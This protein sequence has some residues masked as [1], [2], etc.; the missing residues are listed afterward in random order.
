MRLIRRTGLAVVLGIYACAL[1]AGAL[2]RAGYA[3]QDREHAGEP[4]G[5]SHWLGTDELGRDR[6]ARLLYGARTSLVLAPAA[7]LLAAALA[8]AIGSAAA[9]TGGRLERAALYLADVVASTP[10]F[11]ALLMMRAALP[12]NVDPAVSVA[13]T[14]ALLGLLGWPAGVRPVAARAGSMLR[15]E[16]LR[17]ARATG[18]GPLRLAARHLA[19]NLA[20]VAAAHFWASL[21]VFILAEANLSLLGLGVTEPLPSLGNLM[22]EFRDFRTVALHPWLL[23]PAL[24]LIVTLGALQAISQ[25]VSTSYDSA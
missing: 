24:L 1:G 21:P 20:P 2:A 5:A 14:F 9:W 13:I 12:L 25:S 10:W 7:A 22:S 6:L 17:Q 3:A 8:T 18:I 19:P 15:S 11:F 16:F 23:A 4:P